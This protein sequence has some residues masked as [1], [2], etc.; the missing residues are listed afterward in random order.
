MEGDTKSLVNL[1][2]FL[3]NHNENNFSNDPRQFECETISE[4][5]LHHFRYKTNGNEEKEDVAIELESSDEQTKR[6]LK[7]GQ[8]DCVIDSCGLSESPTILESEDRL[9]SDEPEDDE[10]DEGISSSG[11][12]TCSD[13]QPLSAPF[14]NRL[15]LHTYRVKQPYKSSI[16]IESNISLPTSTSFSEVSTNTSP[17]NSATTETNNSSRTSSQ[18][19]SLSKNPNRD[20]TTTIRLLTTK[21]TPNQPKQKLSIDLA[22]A[23]GNSVANISKNLMSSNLNQVNNKLASHPYLCRLRAS[24][25]DCF[26]RRYPKSCAPLSATPII[27]TSL[28]DNLPN[29]TVNYHEPNRIPDIQGV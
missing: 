9:S 13:S 24:N 14:S 20:S 5:Q 17:K 10:P 6:Q 7:L 11:S 29:I 2:Q 1:G 23:N 27:S 3:P 19:Q 18:D 12:S 25:V 8:T 21:S 16:K 15:R 4:N 26:E 22:G 28:T